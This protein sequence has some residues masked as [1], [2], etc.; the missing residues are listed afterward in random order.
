MNCAKKGDPVKE[1]PGSAPTGKHSVG[2]LEGLKVLDFS[3][4]L[5]GPM[6]TLLLAEA[7][8][9]VVKIEPPGGDP[10]QHHETPAFEAGLVYQLLNRGKHTVQV[11]LKSADGLASVENLV[12]SADVLVEGFRPGVMTKLGLGFE[13][14]RRLNPDII[15]CSLTGF[16]QS[17]PRSHEPG[18]D[19]NYLAVTGLLPA[20]VSYPAPAPPLFTS[21]VGASYAAVT[22]ILIA[23]HG[24]SM[25]LTPDHLDIAM[26]DAVYPFG[27]EQFAAATSTVEGGSMPAENIDPRYSLYRSEDDVVIVVAADEEHYWSLFCGLIDLPHALRDDSVDPA[28]TIDGIASRIAS[29]SADE[30]RTVF[31]ESPCCV[32][33]S[34]TVDD[35]M[36]DPHLL[37]RGLFDRSITWGGRCVPA[38]P[39]PLVPTAR[40]SPS[41]AVAP[42]EV[43]V[44]A[45][46]AE[47][48]QFMEKAVMRPRF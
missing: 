16:G 32:T 31:A 46:G 22:N 24:R 41:V 23:L 26:V 12:R 48:E 7:G 47:W 9:T 20:N 38:L 35:A 44:L 2:A 39:V 25:D 28:A 40:V 10:M 1:H 30:W 8:A 43:P 17:G 19:A 34:A 6:A 42:D 45:R 11:D 4:L 3:T 36:A 18:H 21:G 27:F 5:P 33:V 29:R 15:Y 14:V 13:A 37:R